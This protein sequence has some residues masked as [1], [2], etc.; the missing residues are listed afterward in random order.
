[1]EPDNLIESLLKQQGSGR[2]LPLGL[3]SQL[4]LKKVSLLA[5]TFCGFFWLLQWL[6]VETNQHE[7]K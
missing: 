7:F 1:V 4:Q 2:L 5:T 3:L 6:A